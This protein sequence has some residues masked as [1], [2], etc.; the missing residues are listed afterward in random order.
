MKRTADFIMDQAPYIPPYGTGEYDIEVDGHTWTGYNTAAILGSGEIKRSDMNTIVNDLAPMVQN[1]VIKCFNADPHTS[2]D[3]VIAAMVNGI[4]AFF[5]TIAYGGLPEQGERAALSI[6]ENLPG[7]V[8]A[9]TKAMKKVKDPIKR[10]DGTVNTA[11]AL[12]RS[13]AM[14]G[15]QGASEKTKQIV[16][17][18]VYDT[19]RNF[20][21]SDAHTSSSS[22]QKRGGGVIGNSGIEIDWLSPNTKQMNTLRGGFGSA[23][24]LTLLSTA[25]GVGGNIAGQAAYQAW[26]QK[27]DTGSLDALGQYAK[28]DGSPDPVMD[29]YA[30]YN[31][32]TNTTSG[33]NSTNATS[34]YNGAFTTAANFTN[35]S[36]TWAMPSR[37]DMVYGNISYPNVS[38]PSVPSIPT[39]NATEIKPN[40]Q[41]EP[42]KSTGLVGMMQDHPIISQVA[43]N[44]LYPLITKGVVP[45]VYGALKDSKWAGPTVKK[46]AQKV[47][48]RVGKKTI[49]GFTRT[50]D[51]LVPA[52]INDYFTYLQQ[53]N[54]YR[55][56]IKERNERAVFDAKDATQR[57]K[58]LQR[59]ITDRNKQIEV[60]NAEKLKANKEA[61]QK[62]ITTNVNRQEEYLREKNETEEYNAAVRKYAKDLVDF[63]TKHAH[64]VQRSHEM[65]LIGNMFGDLGKGVGKLIVGSVTDPILFRAALGDYK[66]EL[67]NAYNAVSNNANANNIAATLRQKEALLG[68]LQAT[69]GMEQQLL[70]NRLR[71]FSDTS[72]GF[73]SNMF[74]IM[75]PA[76]PW[77]KDNRRIPSADELA[78]NY[79]RKAPKLPT[80]D[81]VPDA[82]TEGQYIPYLSMPESVST[83]F[84]PYVKE[85]PVQLPYTSK[86]IS[87]LA[88][89]FT[90]PKPKKQN[91]GLSYLNE[92]LANSEPV[93]QVYPGP[94]GSSQGLN[95]VVV[96]AT[97]RPVLMGVRP[98]SGVTMKRFGQIATPLHVQPPSRAPEMANTPEE[99]MHP[100]LKKKRSA[101]VGARVKHSR[102]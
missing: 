43:A 3:Q 88:A 79:L 65:R 40:L 31:N 18:I 96:P 21:Y 37:Q 82:I 28:L 2:V 7:I 35:S 46:L 89:E 20:S 49:K 6:G 67:L 87:D 4:M 101:Q 92:Y 24:G 1:I 26:T 91:K 95:T 45:Y 44:L 76:A 59:G 33:Y 19:A 94:T 99:L 62:A 81:Y 90:A 58:E 15:L 102:L 32:S 11:A 23:L 36:G 80:M 34:G 47:K 25:L 52:A 68:K 100:S 30:D 86:A 77:K 85:A 16:G 50:L 29:A 66:S 61:R 10:L 70:N 8:V 73:F 14:N 38:Y 55:Q 13:S 48:S 54:A 97:T 17:D 84:I 27:P 42:P 71:D 93:E 75:D 63:E 12:L 57:L 69:E 39:A 83:S 72:T 74:E 41:P 78:H 5:G 64:D 22:L 60:A 53:Q 56:A 98:L 51:V 9:T